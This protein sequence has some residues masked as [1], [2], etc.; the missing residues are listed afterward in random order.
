VRFTEQR[1]AAPTGLAVHILFHRENDPDAKP[2]PLRAA[3]VRLPEGTVIDT[4]ALPECAASDDELRALGSEAC[5]DDTRLTIGAFSAMTG[6]PNDPFMGDLHIFNGPS[7]IIEVVTVSGGPASP[8]FDRLT[9]EG[10]TLTAHPPRAAGA[11]PDNE[12]SVRSLDYELPVRVADGRSFATTPP[13]C[14]RSAEWTS[15]GT[16]GFADGS[17]ETVESRTPCALPGLRL[18]VRPKRMTAEEETTLRFRVRSAATRC[19]RGATVLLR[20]ETARTNRRGVA[21]I[22]TRFHAP[23]PRR[24]RVTKPGCRSA[25]ATV[26]VVPAG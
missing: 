23:G 12:A 21:R 16:F 2:S 8:G 5:P 1:S 22:R 9:I 25:H 18:S 4:K 10:S 13:S 7:Q 14:P 20:G 24:A 11:P 3:V 17:T 26:T 6:F 19:V 15:T